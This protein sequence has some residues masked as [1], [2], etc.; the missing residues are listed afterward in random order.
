MR[1][2]RSELVSG[3]DGILE[4]RQGRRDPAVVGGMLLLTDVAV[5]AANGSSWSDQPQGAGT[6]SR[7]SSL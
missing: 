2:S 7:P 4:A 3:R 6:V 5:L 1:K